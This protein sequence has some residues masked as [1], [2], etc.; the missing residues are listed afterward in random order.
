MAYTDQV[1]RRLVASAVVAVIAAASVQGATARVQL[2]IRDGRVWL[3][4]TDATVPEI[5][6]EWARVGQTRVVNAESVIGG[7]LTLQ[8]TDVPEGQA[9]DVLLRSASGFMAVPRVAGLS[10]V[11]QF[12]RIL[13]L[14][15]STPPA[16]AVRASAAPA[17]SAPPTPVFPQP[18]MRADMPGV[19]RVIG[20]DG[21]P[22]PDDQDDLSGG[23]PARP[24]FQSLPRGFSPP[25]GAPPLP[26]LPPQAPSATPTS[27]MGVAVPGTIV[28]PPPPAGPPRVP[29]GRD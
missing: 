6:G 24:Q 21:Q 9:L 29:P 17:I 26:P 25:P 4:A 10:N 27:S 12:D 14:P 13:I 22:V 1:M 3:V 28:Q 2:T 16:G 15:T 23:S 19:E 8:L 7:P 18:A 11:S 5:L 20:A